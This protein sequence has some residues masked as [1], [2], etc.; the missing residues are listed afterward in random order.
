MAGHG[1]STAQPCQEDRCTPCLRIFEAKPAQR[2]GMVLV[3]AESRRGRRLSADNARA[4]LFGYA[5]VSCG[6]CGRG[7][8]GGGGRGNNLLFSLLLFRFFAFCR[9]CRR[10]CRYGFRYSFVGFDDTRKHYQFVTASAVN[11]VFAC[12]VGRKYNMEN[13]ECNSQ[14]QSSIRC[15]RLAILRS[16]PDQKMI[17]GGCFNLIGAAR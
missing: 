2:L 11:P 1:R 6:L 13:M 10:F 5:G 9:F 15:R 4:R 17:Q 7:G 14:N 12:T 3:L 8:R 16:T